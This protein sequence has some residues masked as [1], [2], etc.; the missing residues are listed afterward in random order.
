[1]TIARMSLQVMVAVRIVF[2]QM[3]WERGVEKAIDVKI[4][5]D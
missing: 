1:M 3:M 5:G 4:L 2:D